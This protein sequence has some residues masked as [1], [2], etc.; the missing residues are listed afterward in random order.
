VI[1]SEGDVANV[2]HVAVLNPDGC[3]VVVLTNSR[4]APT[5]VQLRDG[6]GAVK[7]DLLADSVTTL[8]WK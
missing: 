5:T 4:K 8:A 2:H 1:G 7:V 6:S 3:Y